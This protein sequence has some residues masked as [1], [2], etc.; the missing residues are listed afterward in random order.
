[1]FKLII[2]VKIIPCHALQ[3]TPIFCDWCGNGQYNYQYKIRVTSQ[4]NAAAR[5]EEDGGEEAAAG[6]LSLGA[7]PRRRRDVR[8]AAAAAG[9]GGGRGREEAAVGRVRLL[10]AGAAVAGHRLP[11]DQPLLQLQWLLPVTPHPSLS[12]LVSPL[13]AWIDL[14]TWC[15]SPFS[16]S[17]AHIRSNS[18]RSVSG[19][20]FL[21][22]R[23]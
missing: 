6:D 16:V 11:P 22:I 2:Q 15:F 18:S 20:E 9:V 21:R 8:R 19:Y 7:L 3:A 14:L 12:W 10:R 17:A 5:E 13:S 23:S 4:E 1:M